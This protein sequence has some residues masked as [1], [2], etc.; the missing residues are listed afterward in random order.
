MRRSPTPYSLLI[1]P[2]PLPSEIVD[3][4]HFVT[5]DLLNLI[6]GSTSPSKDL[7]SETSSQ[8]LVSRTLS[9]QSAS[10]SGAFGSAQLAPSRGKRG[11]RSECLP[12]PRKG[13]S[14]APRALKIKMRGTNRRRN[15]PGAQVQDS[16]PWV[17]LESSRPSD[18]EEGEEEKEMIGL[19]DRYATRKRK[20]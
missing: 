10:T 19:L 16:V 1:I 2:R 7:E 5:A 9:V 6:A 13:T 20:R 4:E 11:S 15:T 18:L 8:E 14:S 3:E 12:L 17:H